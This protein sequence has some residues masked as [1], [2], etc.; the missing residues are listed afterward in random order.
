[1]QVLQA[2]LPEQKTARQV[3]VD[4]IL[5]NN[6][7]EIPAWVATWSPMAIGPAL[8][9]PSQFILKSIVVQPDERPKL[10]KNIWAFP[11]LV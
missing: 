9:W 8:R 4:R 11:Q 3:Q 5:L 1:M 7:T 6:M 2:S 10:F